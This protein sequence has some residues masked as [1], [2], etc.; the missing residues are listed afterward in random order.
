GLRYSV[1]AFGDTGYADFCGHGRSV[2][3]RLGELGATPIVPRV[4]CEAHDPAPAKRWLDAVIAAL[5]SE[6]RQ[7]PASATPAATTPAVVSASDPP[8]STS[9]STREP[10]TRAR[11]LV[12]PVVHNELLSGA[13]SAKEV[14]RIAFYLSA[15]DVAYSSGDSIGG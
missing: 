4:D 10:F 7:Q 1:L 8:A 14:R 6:G 15:A 13:G 9:L 11:P 5:S 12:T 2:D 3:A